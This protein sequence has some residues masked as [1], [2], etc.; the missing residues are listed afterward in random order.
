MRSEE[1]ITSGLV[2]ASFDETPEDF[3]SEDI[4][5]NEPYPDVPVP[6][7]TEP[8]PPDLNG[9]HKEKHVHDVHNNR[10]KNPTGACS[11]TITT[12]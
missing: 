10:S 8:H 5:N 1:G 3:L 12:L 4:N 7:I 2:E 9:G 6:A 11:G